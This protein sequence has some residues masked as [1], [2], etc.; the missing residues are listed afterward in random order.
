M[1]RKF[2]FENMAALTEFLVGS[3]LALFFHWV[4]NYKEGAFIIFAISILLSLAT[5]LLR[6]EMAKIREALVQHYRQSHEI[7]FALSQITDAEC[8]AK[9]GEV[10]ENVKKTIHILQH[11]YIPLA[12]SEFWLT[13]AKA[14][15]QAAVEVKTVDPLTAGWDSR[16]SMLNYYQAN[17]RALER[18]IRISRI[19]VLN[20]A[21]FAD[22]DVQKVLTT[23]LMDGID[24]RL[25]Y[26]DELPAANDS[27][28][29]A[30][31]SFSF[32][33]Y[34]SHLVTDVYSVPGQFFGRKTSQPA[35]VGKYLRILDM[36]E[37]NAYKL[38]LQDGKPVIAGGASMQ[39]AL[40]A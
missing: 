39:P 38:A 20:R 1:N 6:E 9:A 26:R 31:C 35:E 24:V 2:K 17:L 33:I 18:G 15:E 16:G 29:G 36:I 25:A 5:Y 37:H 27:T 11:G 13:A 14:V 34:D 8:Q 32:G 21:E 4:L 7:T 22:P 10:L 28:W 3:G 19:F 23:Q 30:T 12:E 40:S